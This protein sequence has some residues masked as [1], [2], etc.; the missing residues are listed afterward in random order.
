MSNS[1]TPHYFEWAVKA[2]ADMVIE[3]AQDPSSQ[4]DALRWS[5]LF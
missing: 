2:M 1:L 5:A 4:L 3:A